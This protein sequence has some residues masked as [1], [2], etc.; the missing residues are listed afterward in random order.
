MAVRTDRTP[1]PRSQPEADAFSFPT[2]FETFAVREDGTQVLFGLSV[3]HERSIHLATGADGLRQIIEC[4]RYVE[5][6]ARER[7]EQVAARSVM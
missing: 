7:R 6:L 5:R 3:L 2:G 4:L 1:V